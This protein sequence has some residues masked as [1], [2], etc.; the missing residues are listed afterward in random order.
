MPLRPVAAYDDAAA[1][2]LNTETRILG[3][4]EARAAVRAV[5]FGL[6]QPIAYWKIDSLLRGNWAHELAEA[7]S[8][9]AVHRI[10]VAPAFPEQDRTTVSGIQYVHGMTV[11]E[12]LG[13]GSSSIWQHLRSAGIPSER[14]RIV[15]AQ[16]RAELTGAAASLVPGETPVG[17]AGFARVLWGPLAVRPVPVSGEILIVVGS[18]STRAREQIE[19]LRG[20]PRVAIV[21][22][23]TPERLMSA[24]LIAYRMRAPAA[25]LVTGGATLSVVARVLEF[26]ALRVYGEIAPGVALARVEGGP[27]HGRQI[28][29]KAGDFGNRETLLHAVRMFA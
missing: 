3:P 7:M 29:T 5:L 13:G 23:D 28:I 10:V 9:A 6:R 27:A 4:A 16:T 25:L 8:M 20:L 26:E 12:Y 19:A 15:D 18:A 24:T 1:V 21:E 22:P 17:S 14:F 2:V 11:S